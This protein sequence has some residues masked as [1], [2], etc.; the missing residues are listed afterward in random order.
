MGIQAILVGVCYE[1]TSL[2]GALIMM[3]VPIPVT[4]TTTLTSHSAAAS[5]I[6]GAGNYHVGLCGINLKSASINQNGSTS[7]FVIVTP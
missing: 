4:V 7:G 2:P 1:N 5:V 3:G 6:V